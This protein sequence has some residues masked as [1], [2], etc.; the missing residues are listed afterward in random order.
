MAW[1]NSRCAPQARAMRAALATAGKAP[2][3]GSWT[4]TRMR[5]MGCVGMGSSDH[6]GK[7]RQLLRGTPLLQIAVEAHCDHAQEESAAW[8]GNDI[9]S[10]DRSQ[11]VSH[12][13]TQAF[14][15]L[16]KVG[17]KIDVIAALHGR[18]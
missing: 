11:A 8:C 1:N 16:R 7:A 2:A 17:Q 10:D 15:R 13:R 5:R 3:P 12:E 18:D 9:T 4:A 6:L 14:Q